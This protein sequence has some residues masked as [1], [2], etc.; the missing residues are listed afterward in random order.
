M[1]SS[2]GN[3]PV[4]KQFW[5]AKRKHP[6]SVML[7]RMGDFYETFEDDAKIASD[8]LDITLTKRANG[9]AADVP[10]AG[11]PYHALDQ[12][13]HKLLKAGHKVAICEQVEDPKL[14]KGIV[15]REVVEIVTPGTAVSEKFLNQK[16][17]N[18]F[19]SIVFDKD[20][21]GISLLD[22]STGEFKGVLANTKSLY[23]ILSRFDVTEIIIPETQYKIL[24]DLGLEKSYMISKV[25]NW[26]LDANISYDYLISHFGT[27]SLKGFG[28][29]N[30]ILLT[31]S[32]AF[33]IDYVNNNYM[34]KSSHI[35][36]ISI[37][38]EKGIMNLDSFTV[39]NLELF[40]S[41]SDF[42][43]KG[44]LVN[45]IDK[46]VTS[47]GSRMLKDW[48]R[49]PLTNIEKIN[50]RLDRIAEL[51]S[52]KDVLRTINDKLKSSSDIVRIIS[53]VSMNK[54]N[55]LDIVN[56]ANS[57]EILNSL[58]KNI[59]AKM[60]E[61][62][63]LLSSKINTASIVKEIRQTIV[64]SPP[65]KMSD[66][67]FINDNF[68]ADLDEYRK[69]SKNANDWILEYQESIKENTGIPN[70]KIGYNR[71]FGYYIEV[72][73]SHI[74]SV[75]EDFICKQTLTNA[76]RY[77]TEELKEY[78]NKIL[79]A[80]ENILQ[81]ENMIFDNLKQ[82]IMSQT[83]KILNNASIISKIDLSQ[84]FASLAISKNYTR[85]K[86]NNGHKIIIKDG[87]HPVIECLNQDGLEFIP[88]D[89]SLNKKDNQIMIITGPNMAGKSTYL[90]Q[91]GL[92][93]IMA[94]IG[95][96]VPASSASIGIIDKLFTRVGASDNLTK[97]EST[98][99]VEMNETANI[100]NNLTSKSLIL[101]DEVGRGTST[102]DG[103]AIAWAITEFLHNV[104][105]KPK[106]LF[107]THYHELVELAE[108]LKSAKNYNIE[109][110][111][112][113]GNLIF[114]RK[115]IEGGTDKS[116]GIHV[117]KM[118]GVPSDV[119]NRAIKVLSSLSSNKKDISD[120][121]NFVIT[122]DVKNN[123][124]CN[125]KLI[126][127]LDSIDVDNLSPIEAIIKLNELKQIND[128]NNK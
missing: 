81:I 14:A 34:G 107:A 89:I 12:Y 52:D 121:E 51:I 62:K 1:V 76:Q 98:F 92:I 48:I 38:Q 53:K 37:I 57:L 10:L 78:E 68:S 105:D 111:E 127:Y 83:D 65:V 102:Y 59:K 113:E 75:P 39:R 96:Y 82:N 104:K 97:G 26:Y 5:D 56:L 93:V 124:D 20:K 49:Q 128:E 22:V 9:S 118:A 7:F 13:L 24:D 67:G 84:S 21:I 99:L 30:Q 110:R 71:V 64:D 16:E 87:R 11:F 69:I 120:I 23:N 122:K 19:A 90:R 88:N 43:S 123:S 41:L 117:A 45:S 42:S 112:D 85:P 73:K 44:T 100:L 91:V 60:K 50:K 115:I 94:Q 55:P 8:I 77:F 2:K 114:L 15:K 58:N 109:V 46:T 125:E 25:Q 126:E 103:L 116:Y 66:G 47:G 106:T 3:T 79:H 36:S 95:C 54:A 40:K 80:K 72:S 28:L 29:D 61:T 35:T 18:F 17:N 70:I 31:K 108:K 6:D 119:V 74:K 27:N 101:L 63:K 33:A 32:A 86:I 4:M